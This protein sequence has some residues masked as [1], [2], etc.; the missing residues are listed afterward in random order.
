M[1][2]II[3]TGHGHFATGLKSTVELLAGPQANMSFVDFTTGM[4]DVLLHTALQQALTPDTPTVFFCD[5]LGG[6][7]FKQAVTLS[8][9][10]AQP[11]EVVAGAN[12]A[13]L[14]EVAFTLADAT[15]ADALADQLVSASQQALT[16]F[17]LKKP[18][19]EPDADEDGI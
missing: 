3:V 9:Q 5:L 13:A 11:I 1:A 12:V 10:V 2:K 4:D 15:D 7:P 6:T 19:A 14:L 8:T 16:H 18:V 17:K